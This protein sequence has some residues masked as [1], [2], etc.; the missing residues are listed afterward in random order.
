M[1][2]L[3]RFALFAAALLA[4]VPA[5]AQDSTVVILVRHAERASLSGNNDPP[6]TEAGE[7]RARALAQALEGRQIHAVLTTE[8]QRTRNTARP[9]AEARGLSPEIVSLAAGEAHVDSVAAAVRRHAGHTVL[10]VGHSN[11]VPGIIGAL[12]GPRLPDLC[13]GE[14]SNL[15]ILVLKRDAEPRLERHV[16]GEP[17]PPG[18][19][20]CPP[21]N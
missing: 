21:A 8:R 2:R 3:L 12:G 11:T 7:A 14:Y 18:A 19:N 20:A 15:F 17:D 5:A 13:D 10:V 9:A 6:L 1:P 16:Y 4:A